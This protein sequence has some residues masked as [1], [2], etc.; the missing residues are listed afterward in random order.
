[1][2]LLSSRAFTLVELMIVLAIIG[3]L[4][5][6]LFP[7]MTGFLERARDTGRIA[8]LNNSK[9]NIQ[10]FNAEQARYPQPADTVDTGN[11]FSTVDGDNPNDTFFQQMYTKRKIPTDP[12]ASRTTTPCANAGS[13]GYKYVDNGVNYMLWAHLENN[14]RGNL[15]IASVAG[16]DT[17]VI[18]YTSSG[19]AYIVTP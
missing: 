17:V 3:I 6:A 18:D 15:D 9:A 13:Y 8:D 19:S 11:C 12:Q 10:T 1:M 7:Q 4:A 5:A 2:R 16:V 14:A